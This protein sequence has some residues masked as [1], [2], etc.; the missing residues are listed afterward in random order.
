MIVKVASDGPYVDSV[1]QGSVMAGLLS[2]GDVIVAVDD[3]NTRDMTT[4]EVS[5]LLVKVKFLFI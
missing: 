3:V 2:S 1:K 4:Q 5:D